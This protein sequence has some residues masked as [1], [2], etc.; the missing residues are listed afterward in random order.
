MPNT[1][2]EGLQVAIDFYGSKKK[3]AEIA[4]VSKSA[5]SQ[6]E[7][8]PEKAITRIIMASKRKLTPQHLRPDLFGRK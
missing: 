6:W 7:L 1:P 4:G 3:L 2:A 5:V 8:I